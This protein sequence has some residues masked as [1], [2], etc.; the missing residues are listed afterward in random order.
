[1]YYQLSRPRQITRFLKQKIASLRGVMMQFFALKSG[2]SA[3]GGSTDNTSIPAPAIISLLS[4]SARS[5]FTMIGPLEVLS[6]KADG[7]IFFKFSVL[8][9]PWVSGVKGQWM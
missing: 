4:A 5:A 2:L 6:R 3:G 9:K 8:I 7:F 1:M